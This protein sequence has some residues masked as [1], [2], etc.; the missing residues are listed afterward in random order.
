MSSPAGWASC[1]D[2]FADH[3]AFQRQAIEDGSPEL[4]TP[5]VPSAGLGPLPPALLLSI[6]GITHEWHGTSLGA[7]GDWSGDGADEL[8]IGAQALGAVG[9]WGAGSNGGAYVVFSEELY[10]AL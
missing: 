8:V 10:P 4:V 5:F 6:P 2:S 9:I 3:L 1:L 7:V